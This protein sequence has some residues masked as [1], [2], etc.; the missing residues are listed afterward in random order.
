MTQTPT[1]ITTEQA[2]RDELSVSERHDLLSSDRRRLVLDALA[3]RT[4]P[5]G[6]T[7]LASAVAEWEAGPA[8]V[9]EERE[10]RVRIDLHHVHL[11]KLSDHGVI[12]YDPDAHVVEP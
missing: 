7:E 9:D 8:E 5:I 2:E 12:G 10:E 6:L 11:P 3:E 1:E 4:E